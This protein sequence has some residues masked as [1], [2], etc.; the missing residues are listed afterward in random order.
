MHKYSIRYY[1]KREKKVKTT[2]VR[3]RNTETA[4]KQYKELHTSKI[5][6]VKQLKGT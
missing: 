4:R 1:S 2:H 3:A 5:Y 6:S